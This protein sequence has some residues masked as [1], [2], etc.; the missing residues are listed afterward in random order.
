MSTEGDPGPGP[1]ARRLFE[2]LVRE[3]ADMLMAFLR[4]LLVNTQAAEDLFQ[5]TMLVAW[6]RLGECDTS[7]PMAPWLRGIAARLALEHRRKA[8]HRRDLPFGP[9]MLE[10]LELEFRRLDLRPGDTFRQRIDR[11]AGCLN[12]LPPAMREAVDLLYHRGLSLSALA[13][14]VGSTTEAVKKRIQRARQLLADCLE[15]AP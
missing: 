7:M 1:S 4:S 8:A 6:R 5:E 12:A 10:A 11:L 3:H 13:A 9:D 2:I 15:G 14:A